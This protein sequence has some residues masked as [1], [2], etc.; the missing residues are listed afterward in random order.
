MD[1][2]ATGGKLR[3]EVE[4]NETVIGGKTRNATRASAK[5]GST[6]PARKARPSQ[7]SGIVCN[8]QIGAIQS[9][10]IGS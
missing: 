3:G 7:V 9:I 4:V 2:G 6:I 1:D 8:Q 5:K 10:A